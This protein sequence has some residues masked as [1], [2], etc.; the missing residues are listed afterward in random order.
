MR[1][2]V[3][4]FLVCLLAGALGVL[5]LAIASQPVAARTIDAGAIVAQREPAPDQGTILALASYNGQPAYELP[6]GP[7][8]EAAMLFVPHVA[9]DD[10][11]SN[12]T[13]FM[14]NPS[15]SAVATVV[16]NFYQQD[17]TLVGTH[18][19]T[20]PPHGTLAL[21][22]A[23]IPWLPTGY[24]G[25]A[26]IESDQPVLAIANLQQTD[27]N[28]LLS[29]NSVLTGSVEV[30]L[31]GIM[32]EYYGWNTSFWVQN[33]SPYAVNV[34]LEFYPDIIGNY[35]DVNVTIPA[36]TSYGSFQELMPELGAS[37]YGSVLIQAD[38]PVVAVVEMG[39]LAEGSAGA[40]NGTLIGDA[41]T[42]FFSPRQQ[43]ETNVWS[44]AAVL[45]NVGAFDATTDA[46]WYTG[47]GS[48]VFNETSLVA[49]GEH[50]AHALVGMPGIPEGFDGSLFG[51][52][53]Q[54]MVGLVQFFDYVATGDA[55]A[56][57]PLLS[58]SQLTGGGAAP[59][60][61]H[62]PR[63]AHVITAGLSTEFSIQ[64]AT[65]VS[66]TASVT[67]TFYHESGAAT[68][69]VFD[70]LPHHGVT[71]YATGDVGA[72]GPNWEGAVTISSTQPIAVEAMQKVEGGLPPD[73]SISGHVWDGNGDPLPGVTVSAGPGGSA[74]T[75][76]SG[77][78]L[79]TGVVT[80]TYTLTP[81]LSGWT[82]TPPT[83]V[84]TVPPNATGQNFVGQSPCP[85]PLAG[86]EIAGPTIGHTGTLH[87]YT[88]VI[89]P[90]D[91]TTPLTYTWSP[92]P[93]SGQGTAS[94]G[95][96][97]A[98]PGVFS[99]TLQ[100][101]NCGGPVSDTQWVFVIPD[102]A[103]PV[104]PEEGGVLI[105]TDTQGLTTTVHVPPGAVS[106][107][108]VLLYTPVATVTASADFVFAGHAFDL[109]AY[110]EN[111]EPLPGLVFS[112]PATV[113]IHY[114]EADVTGINETALLLARW[115]D[116][117]WVDAACGPY[118]RHPDQNWLA[119]PICHLSR[120]ALLGQAKYTIYL[121]L[122]MRNTP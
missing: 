49:P 33:T 72:L 20:I 22:L 41:D 115:Q 118:D 88:A 62:L 28:G 76:L 39:N 73:Y 100:A 26:I 12:A 10:P 2:T 16:V 38:Q 96:Q 27:A 98:T 58:Q 54:P 31:P 4:L 68:A 71:R 23:T 25:S 7:P 6:V 21:E 63:V 105:Y 119:T 66:A 81:S 107:T 46:T 112:V 87:T 59:Y 92:E 99:L 15:S 80:G 116:S 36:L 1:K 78:Y 111:G 60:V 50:V 70:T 103:V 114:S 37:F 95:Y 30:S 93:D 57:N 40:Y 69:I 47:D 56:V 14:Q 42:S 94:A 34:T 8:P 17:G 32:R 91:A 65:G 84:V 74:L 35:H 117:T 89:T 45:L 120:F 3:I 97:W 110:Q 108:I 106:E 101:E 53:D 19:D 55:L 9:R 13:L 11:G 122:V 85:Q 82:F 43:K 24:Q 44:S 52:A 79:I 48:W 29:Y 86:V 90:A 51:T 77:T 121:P 75:G 113:T 67:I 61:M 18:V 102:T 83:R 64:N 109:D 5:L 104:T